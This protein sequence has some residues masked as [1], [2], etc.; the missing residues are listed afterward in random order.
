MNEADLALIQLFVLK[1]TGIVLTPEK[2]Y[3]VETRL[4]PVARQMKLAGLAAI[5]QRLRHGD[6]LVETQVI[7]AMTTNETLFFRDRLPFDAFE[8]TMLPELISARRS[9]GRIRIWCA[10]C[11]T[12]QEPYSLAMILDEKRHELAGINVEILAT[13]VSERVLEQAKA[14]VYSQ[15]EVQRGLPIKLLMK[16]F[17]QVETR[18]KINPALGEKISYKPFNLLNPFRQLGMFDIIFCRNVLIYFNETT[19]RDVLRRFSEVMEPDSYLVL[20]GAESVLGLSQELAPHKDERILC[21]HAGS[22]MASKIG[23]SFMRQRMSA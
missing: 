19:K 18:W 20:G 15:F 3:L 5:A 1:R 14:G 21:V 23:Q 4:E 16:H 8:K 9:R 7:D 13:D 17:T 10:A 22:P 2:R 6:R 11:S 12:G